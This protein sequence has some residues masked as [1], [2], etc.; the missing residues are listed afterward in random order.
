MF[1]FSSF[2][3]IDVAETV[4]ITD[5]IAGCATDLRNECKHYDFGLEKSYRDAD[6]VRKS[7]EAFK[8]NRPAKWLKFIECFLG[9]SQI[10][11]HYEIS[12]DLV[13]QI[14]H[15]LVNGNANMTPF[16]IAIA[17]VIH[18]KCRN[19]H[20]MILM[21]RMKICISYESM[22]RI[23]TGLTKR[24][25]EMAEGHRVPIPSQIQSYIMIHGAM[26]NFDDGPSHDTILMLFQNYHVIDE[27]GNLIST[28]K[29]NDQS[30]RF[31]TI[32][33]CQKVVPSLIGSK[34]GEIPANYR[35][36]SNFGERGKGSFDELLWMWT[37]LRYLACRISEE[38]SQWIPSFS[39]TMGIVSNVTPKPSVKAF[40]PIYPQNNII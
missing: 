32:L 26:D 37:M 27:S 2:K 38:R 17:Q 34:R 30:R 1:F 6:D 14:F 33:E 20:L 39:S 8:Q 23:D 35:I 7:Y 15:A 36:S 19:K 4:R 16:A 28:K 10:P 22:S 12:V 18:E 5:T 40:T 11:S 29:D 9:K 31:S 24:V 21:N 25:V 3:V 13:F